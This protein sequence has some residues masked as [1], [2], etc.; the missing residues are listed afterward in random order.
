MTM[1]RQEAGRT[2][3]QAGG[4]GS[5]TDRHTYTRTIRQTHTHNSSNSSNV[6]NNNN[7]NNINSDS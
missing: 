4:Q 1:Y 5:Q 7:C 3:R 2:G 6:N